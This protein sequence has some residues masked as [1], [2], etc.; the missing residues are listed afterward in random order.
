VTTQQNS[1]DCFAA[2]ICPVCGGPLTRTARALHCPRRHNFDQAGAGYFH[3]LPSGHGRTRLQGDVSEMLHARQQFLD[4]GF[5][6]PIIDALRS[7]IAAQ[8]AEH[9][10]AATIV[11]A[12]CGTGHYI[13]NIADGLA[14]TSPDV[15]CYFG[16]DVSKDA[17]RLAARQHARVTFL[18]NDLQQRIT[19]ADHSVAVL[20]NIFAPRNAV[21]FAR[22][23]QRDGALII[24]IPK[25]SHLAELRAALPM[26]SMRPEKRDRLLEQLAEHFELVAEKEVEYHRFLQA[27]DVVNLLRMGPNYWHLD[28]SQVE[29]ARTREGQST[30]GFLVMAFRKGKPKVG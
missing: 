29:Q 18:V 23:L 9:A 11:E 16:L 7:L 4:R 25:E 14:D 6:E 30:L 1:S 12:G 5:H 26:L 15:H 19:F 10:P 3:L 22:V 21:E 24:V 27:D 17:V 8:I 13:A 20:L 2:L 28:T